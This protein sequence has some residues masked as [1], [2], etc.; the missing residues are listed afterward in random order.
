[1]GGGRRDAVRVA[2][3]LDFPVLVPLA[4]RFHPAGRAD[5]LGGESQTTPAHRCRGREA[6]ARRGGDG[7]VGERVQP[8]A[9]LHAGYVWDDLRIAT[10]GDRCTRPASRQPSTPNAL[11][12]GG[13]GGGSAGVVASA[14]DGGAEARRAVR[15]CGREWSS[16]MSFELEHRSPPH[17]STPR[18]A[19]LGR[20]PARAAM[21]FTSSPRSPAASYPTSGIGPIPTAPRLG[22]HADPHDTL[23]DAAHASPWQASSTPTYRPGCV[24]C[25]RAQPSW[26]RL[27]TRTLRAQAPSRRSPR[28][29]GIRPRHHRRRPRKVPAP[30]RR[31]RPRPYPRQPHPALTRA[32][33]R[34][35]H[36][37]EE[38]DEI[39]GAAE[40]AVRSWQASDASPSPPPSL[41]PSLLAPSPSPSHCHPHSSPSPRLSRRQPLAVLQVR[42]TSGTSLARI[43]VIAATPSDVQ[44]CAR[45]SQQLA[46]DAA[47]QAH[48]PTGACTSSRDRASRVPRTHADSS[49]MS[50]AI[51][52]TAELVDRPRR[53]GADDEA[54]TTRP[55]RIPNGASVLRM[56]MVR[57]YPRQGRQRHGRRRVKKRK[58]KARRSRTTTKKTSSSD[59]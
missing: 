6:P 46:A 9:L 54:A 11:G 50:P 22:Q 7:V 12:G 15:A 41:Q 17:E 28:A 42:H 33:H 24:S 31:P 8:R 1:M 36:S 44:A 21:P 5:V 27:R 43:V 16:Q 45:R 47:R 35:D 56:R 4:L 14:G 32:L 25:S 59:D 38:D 55:R 58:Q 29:E 13:G 19:P 20:D 39:L 2:L 48:R 40:R 26:R 30:P 18:C 52:P 57:A 23:A 53:R 51:R 3:C 10:V 34:Y 49:E 37:I